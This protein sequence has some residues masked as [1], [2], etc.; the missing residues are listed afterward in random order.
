[1]SVGELEEFDSV[2][3]QVGLNELQPAVSDLPLACEVSVVSLEGAIVSEYVW[4]DAWASEVNLERVC[5]AGD[6]VTLLG[7]LGNGLNYNWSTGASTPLFNCAEPGTTVLGLEVTD[8]TGCSDSDVMVLTV[9]DCTSGLSDCHGSF[10]DT[11]WEG[12]LV[13]PNPF[14]GRTS[15]V[16]VSGEDVAMAALG[17]PGTSR[18]RLVDASGTE[19]ALSSVAGGHVHLDQPR[20]ARCPQACGPVSRALAMRLHAS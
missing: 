4:V 20:E 19:V 2:T 10:G 3:W 9:D 6:L 15:L 8:A 13:V 17:R 7:P 11:S 18:G 14:I 5:P 1:M 12:A 16:G